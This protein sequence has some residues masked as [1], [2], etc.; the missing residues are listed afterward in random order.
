MQEENKDPKKLYILIA[1]VAIGVIAAIVSG[2]RFLGPQQANIIGH[3]EA[4]KGGLRNAEKGG[5]AEEQ[6]GAGKEEFKGMA[7]PINP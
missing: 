7:K 3:L 5:P 4:P 2:V 6:S 1:L